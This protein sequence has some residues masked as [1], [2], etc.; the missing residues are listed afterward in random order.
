MED[1]MGWDGMGWDDRWDDEMRWDGMID[2]MGRDE[3]R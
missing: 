2:G 3:I 1:E